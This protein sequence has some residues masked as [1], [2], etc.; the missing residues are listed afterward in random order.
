ME[1]PRF[2]GQGLVRQLD[3][4]ASTGRSST[5]PFASS[6]KPVAARPIA[7]REPPVLDDPLYGLATPY[8][9]ELEVGD[10]QACGE[11]ASLGRLGSR[12]G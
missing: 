6:R 2:G 5:P 8:L 10:G 1:F 11:Q 3:C 7:P 9:P 4:T 12:G